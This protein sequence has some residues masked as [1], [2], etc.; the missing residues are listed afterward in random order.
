M[1]KSKMQALARDVEQNSILED[2]VMELLHRLAE[3]F[4][5]NVVSGSCTLAKHRRCTTLGSIKNNPSFEPSI[6]RCSR[7]KIGAVQKLANANSRIHGRGF[8]KSQEH[9]RGAQATH[10][11]HP[12]NIEKMRKSPVLNFS[13]VNNLLLFA[14]LSYWPNLQSGSPLLLFPFFRCHT[15]VQ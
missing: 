9:R 13:I 1:P 11:T 7:R 2:D 8:Q 5:E 3:D 14:S 10:A 6:F 15:L 12:Q 4:V